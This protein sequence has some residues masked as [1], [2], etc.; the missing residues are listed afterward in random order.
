MN[1][2]L[3]ALQADH[4]LEITRLLN[5]HASRHT[6]SNAAELQGQVYTQQVV[7]NHLKQQLKQLVS[8]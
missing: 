2:Q 5:E 3:N 6:Q 7:I 8:P 4:D 1:E